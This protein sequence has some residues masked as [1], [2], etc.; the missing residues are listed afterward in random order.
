VIKFIFDIDGADR[1]AIPTPGALG[2]IYIARF[3]ADVDLIVADITSNR[4][5]L[6]VSQ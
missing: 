5:D 4:F 2:L 1:G 6:T 3:A